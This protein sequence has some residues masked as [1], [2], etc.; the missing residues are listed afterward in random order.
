[1]KYNIVCEFGGAEKKNSDSGVFSA[2]PL[3]F[4]GSLVFSSKIFNNS[5]HHNPD[6]TQSFANYVFLNH[7]SSFLHLFKLVILYTELS[8]R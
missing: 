4:L 2:Q 3:H 7:L 5:N 1:M 6:R 8:G